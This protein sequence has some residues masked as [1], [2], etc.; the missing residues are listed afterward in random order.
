MHRGLT[1]AAFGAICAW[2]ALVLGV[3][4]PAGCA[5]RPPAAEKQ[6][7]ALER[8]ALH[9]YPDF[10]DDLGFDGLAE[11]MDR[12][13]A[14]LG[15]MPAGRPFRFGPDLYEA[16][17]LVR[18]MGRLKRFLQTTPSRRELNRF[19]RRHY[20]V[21]RSRG[22]D[23][24]GRVLFT[25]YYE[26]VLTGSS[27]QT[28][29]FRYPLYRL[30]KD[31]LTVD[32]SLFGSAYEGQ[33]ITARC[34]DGQ[35]LPYPD[36]R[37]IEEHRALAGKADAL[38]WLQDRVDLFFLHIQGSGRIYLE[39]G[40]VLHAH[41]HATNGRAYRSIGR[42]LIEEGKIAR[43]EMSMQRIRQY[44]QEHPDDIGRIL[45]TNPSYVFF[46]QE[47]DGPIGY[48]GAKLTPGRSLA[49]D[50]RIFP[51]G[52][53]AYMEAKKPLI[54]GDGRIVQWSDLARFVVHQDTGGAIRG[55]GRGDLFWGHGPYA[56]IAAGHLQHPGRLYFMVLKPET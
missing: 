3:F 51:M 31:L 11:A 1:Q 26:P 42:L 17:H 41:Y 33:K 7:P 8:L 49:L 28:P 35:V 10:A 5:V 2:L 16:G 37:Q 25:G 47:P 30:P 23:G 48:M 19:I 9:R 6:P 15:K 45:N 12:S 38:A 50:R 21:Y 54:C 14:Y 13:M 32:L 18:S 20:R 53:L 44:L 56:E 24:V 27:K 34:V 39:D 29:R 55:A 52:A 40:R 4:L 46:K 36:R 22:S 43:T